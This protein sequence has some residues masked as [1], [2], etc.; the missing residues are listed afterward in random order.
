MRSTDQ[1]YKSHAQTFQKRLW[2]D[3]PISLC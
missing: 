1:R 2:T 3:G